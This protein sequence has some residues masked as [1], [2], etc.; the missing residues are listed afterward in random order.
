MSGESDFVYEFYPLFLGDKL[1]RSHLDFYP[2]AQLRP[3]NATRDFVALARRSEGYPNKEDAKGAEDHAND[4]SV[5]GEFGPP[6][7]NPLRGQVLFLALVL[8][9]GLLNFLHAIRVDLAGR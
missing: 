1:G 6:G 7:R 4:R 5:P 8:A 3:G 2:R 9:G